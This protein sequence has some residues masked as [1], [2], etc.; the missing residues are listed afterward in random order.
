[1]NKFLLRP[2]KEWTTDDL[3]GVYKIFVGL[4]KDEQELL[5]QLSKAS[6]KCLNDVAVAKSTVMVDDIA[7]CNVMPDSD[8]GKFSM[9]YC[10]CMYNSHR[11]L[12]I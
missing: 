7:E 5:I 9:M 10:F 2:L 8:D 4:S 6:M 11:N 3:E 1:M 12:C